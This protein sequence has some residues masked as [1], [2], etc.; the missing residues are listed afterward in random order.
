MNRVWQFIRRGLVTTLSYRL[1]FVLSIAGIGVGAVRFAYM[2]GFLQ[3]GNSFPGIEGYGGDLMAYLLT[4]VLFMTFLGVSLNA[5]QN[6]IRQEQQMG[7]LEYLLLSDAPLILLVLLGGLWDFVW[8]ALSSAAMFAVLMMGFGVPMNPNLGTALLVLVV[9]ILCLSGLG[10]ISAGIIMVTKIGDPITWVFSTL[11]GF[12]SGVLFPVESLPSWL[13]S[14]SSLLPPTYAL[15]ALR[16]ALIVGATPNMIAKELLVLGGMAVVVVPLGCGVFHW[17]FNR[18][19][20]DGT[21]VE[22]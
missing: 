9:S 7:T 15:A 19:R 4:G 18:A 16:K 5:F 10:L 8:V 12:L 22:Y 21:L 3:E 17:G 20:R 2:A 13:Q 14:I 6:S 1:A 11:S